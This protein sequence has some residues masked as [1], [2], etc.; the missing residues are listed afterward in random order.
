M[1]TLPDDDLKA[2]ILPVRLVIFDVDGVL[3]DGRIVYHDDGTETKAFDV[4]DGHG[5]KLLLRSGLDAALI[6]GRSSQVVLHRARDLGVTRVYQNAKRK[7]DAYGDLLA[8]TGLGEHELAYVGDDLIDI[9]IMRRVGFSVAVADASPHVFP[10]AHYVT[11]APGG[12]GAAREVCELLLS[13]QRR[14]EGVTRR[15]FE[16]S[17]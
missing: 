5:I 10:F 14:W 6:T 9:P 13:V 2:R 16:D 11:R 7:L 12:R 17:L 8:A 4:K 1:P 15:Y 3:T